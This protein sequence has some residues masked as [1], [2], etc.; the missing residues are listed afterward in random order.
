M[1]V[2]LMA[3]VW[4]A[5]LPP[6]LKLVLLAVADHANDEGWAY[7]GQRSLAAKCGMAERTVRGHLATLAEQGWLQV[8]RRGRTTT[9][10]YR[11]VAPGSDRQPTA[12][13]PGGERQP[14]AGSDRQPTAGVS[15][16]PPPLNHQ[17]TTTR[18]HQQQVGAPRGM[19]WAWASRWAQLRQVPAPD[20]LLA[21][22]ARQ[23]TEFVEA[24][25]MPD[26][27]L[28]QRALDRG[29]EQPAGWGFAVQGVQ[30]A[31]PAWVPGH[32]VQA[33]S[34]PDAQVDARWEREYGYGPRSPVPADK[35]AVIQVKARMLARARAGEP[36]T[37]QLVRE[38]LQVAAQELQKENA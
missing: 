37:E 13:H 36:V 22:W 33:A 38:A 11:V 30:P 28:L 5:A 17:R 12:S 24:G 1:S 29:I 21:T 32:I 7:P 26:E 14:T 18:N 23:V 31:W 25:G 19:A 34:R 10:L 15:G 20:S 2:R 8:Q 6:H 16:S 27:Q 3:N 35:R 4:D 9:N